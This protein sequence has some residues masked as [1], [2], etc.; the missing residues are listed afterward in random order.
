MGLWSAPNGQ[1][2]GSGLVPSIT[3]MMEVKPGWK[4]SVPHFVEGNII[5][6]FHISESVIAMWGIESNQGDVFYWS[7][8]SGVTWQL[9]DSIQ[10]NIPLHINRIFFTDTSN[11]WAVG[12][13]GTIIHTTNGGVSFVEEEEI[14]EM[15]TEFLLSQ[16]YPNPFNPSTSIQIRSKQ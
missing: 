13:G 1:V 11:G 12:E 6:V 2:E 8:D 7:T 5:D 15:P 9:R 14:D 3:P 16:N 10:F 4:I